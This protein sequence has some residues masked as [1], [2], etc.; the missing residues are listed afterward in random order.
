MR[1]LIVIKMFYLEKQQR[2]NITYLT[3]IKT[4]PFLWQERLA[5][6]AQLGSPIIYHTKDLTEKLQIELGDEYHVEFAMRYK[7]PS[8]RKCLENLKANGLI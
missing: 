8:L 1:K 7:N 5:S 3:S 2:I 4:I 6:H